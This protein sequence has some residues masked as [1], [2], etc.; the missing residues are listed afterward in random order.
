MKRKKILLRWKWN[1]ENVDDD[2]DD[3]IFGLQYFTDMKRR[4]YRI[5]DSLLS[6]LFKAHDE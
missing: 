6:I 2:D 4:M 5:K 3:D 1:G